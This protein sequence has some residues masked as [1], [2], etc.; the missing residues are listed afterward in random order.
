MRGWGD[1]P[2]GPTGL[3]RT[4]RAGPRLGRQAGGEARRT[5]RPAFME[6]EEAPAAEH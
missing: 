6:T 1:R 3:W 2:W 4:E 5:Q